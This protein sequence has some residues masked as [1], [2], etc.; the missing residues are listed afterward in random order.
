VGSP[1]CY[2]EKTRKI[3]KITFGEGGN[4]GRELGKKKVNRIRLV[5]EKR[6]V[7]KS[8]SPETTGTG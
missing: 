4:R 2:I 3:E 1:K 8:C 7:V 6:T 5:Q